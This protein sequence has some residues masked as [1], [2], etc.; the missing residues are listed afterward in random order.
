M[1]LGNEIKW[2]KPFKLI[3]RNK[4][5]EELTE[6]QFATLSG[7]V[8]EIK[9][10]KSKLEQREKFI[11]TQQSIIKGMEELYNNTVKENLEKELMTQQIV[12]SLKEDNKSILEQSFKN[13]KNTRKKKSI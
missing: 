3:E 7:Y 9:S 6:T 12:T 1:K 13:I 5:L 10:I 11:E 2:Y 8:D 4:Q